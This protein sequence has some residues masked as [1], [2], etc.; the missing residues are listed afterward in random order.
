MPAARPIG[1][2]GGGPMTFIAKLWTLWTTLLAVAL[3]ASGATAA[4]L[5]ITY[6]GIVTYGTDLHDTFGAGAGNSLIGQN[7]QLIFNYDTSTM[8]Y[9]ALPTQ[10]GVQGS[11]ATAS[12][13][14]T[15]GTGSFTHTNVTSSP[16]TFRSQNLAVPGQPQYLYSNLT[17]SSGNSATFNI[18]VLSGDMFHSLDLFSVMDYVVQPT[19]SQSGYFSMAGNGLSLSAQRVRSNITEMSAVPAPATWAMFIGGFG[20]VGGAM[21]R[22]KA[23][24]SF[25]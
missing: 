4:P 14:L 21:R 12:A 20:L 15:I 16:F 13:T 1:D 2:R 3:L 11:G 19:D 5:I 10:H 25:G 24:V 18:Q 23:S 7:F 9:E 6:T 17:P 8:A 22:R